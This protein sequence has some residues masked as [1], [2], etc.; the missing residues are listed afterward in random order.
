MSEAVLKAVP[1]HLLMQRE[2][3]RQIDSP[4]C[5]CCV[6]E[7]EDRSKYPTD[8]WNNMKIQVQARHGLDKFGNVY[9]QFEWENGPVGIY[10]HKTCRTVFASQR[11]LEQVKGRKNNLEVLSITSPIECAETSK[12][13]SAHMPE[14]SRL[15]R[16]STGPLHDKDLCVWC[17]KPEDCKHAERGS[18]CLRH[19]P[20]SWKT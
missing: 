3:K 1:D 16:S 9:E 2:E 11:T 17:M 13:C 18:W 7:N 10:F 14:K 8:S 12:E 4:T 19:T 20:S 6:E 15:H 5:A